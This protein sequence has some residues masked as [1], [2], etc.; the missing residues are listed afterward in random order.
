MSIHES[1]GYSSATRVI[2]VSP[3]G[4]PEPRAAPSPPPAATNTA[5]LAV[6]TQQRLA[7]RVVRLGAPIAPW[8]LGAGGRDDP[9][10]IGAYAWPDRKLPCPPG[11][12][13]KE[14]ECHD[15]FASNPHLRVSVVLGDRLYAFVSTQHVLFPDGRAI[16]QKFVGGA[17]LLDD[18]DRTVA[19]FTLR[20]QPPEK[21]RNVDGLGGLVD[22]RSSGVI[23]LEPCP[24][25]LTHHYEIAPVYDTIQDAAAAFEATWL[26]NALAEYVPPSKAEPA[27]RSRRAPRGTPETPTPA[28]AKPAAPP[29][30]SATYPSEI[31][32]KTIIELAREEFVP[33]KG[34]YA[35]AVFDRVTKIAIAGILAGTAT[36]INN[37]DPDE[38]ERR[39]FLLDERNGV[40]FD[41]TMHMLGVGDPGAGKGR[42]QTQ[43]ERFLRDSGTESQRVSSGSVQGLLGSV[44]EKGEVVEGVIPRLRKA[45]VVFFPEF[46]TALEL[47]NSDPKNGQNRGAL[48]EW[49]S[50]H[51]YNHWVSKAR[52]AGVRR[53]SYAILMGFLQPAFLKEFED[54]GAGSIRRLVILRF[55]PVTRDATK[56]F[57]TNVGSAFLNVNS[58]NL[59]AIRAKLRLIRE[60][61]RPKPGGV[62]TGR[63]DAWFLDQF[64]RGRFDH[65]DDY[66]LVVSITMG[67]YLATLWFGADGGIELPSPSERPELLEIIDEV[68]RQRD[69]FFQDP[70]DLRVRE[71]T[72][73]LERFGLRTKHHGF[74]TVDLILNALA[75][76]SRAS[77]GSA[78]KQ[79]FG[80]TD[81][82]KIYHRGLLANPAAAG[83]DDP[84]IVEWVPDPAEYAGDERFYWTEAETSARN[85]EQYDRALKWIGWTMPKTGG[86]RPTLYRFRGDTLADRNRKTTE[87]GG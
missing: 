74:L 65:T 24:V 47:L 54:T 9:Q 21:L 28:E 60:R 32:T 83:M 76:T 87:N 63:V 45:G 62:N 86:R 53:T 81:R 84:P 82:D 66:R 51:S 31:S 11:R 48:L 35:K 71:D 75:R 34:A 85:D 7:V 26:P 12:L 8:E 42:V 1:D 78:R 59:Q 73:A 57:V 19:L 43:L 68:F 18:R 41:F 16:P 44:L 64:D 40:P 33:G 13:T 27:R 52:D 79:I 25:D 3:V 56:D 80:W 38:P 30:V 50:S 29:P 10:F 37:E 15:L 36:W 70:D 4:D 2:T 67:Y 58:E 61:F 69:Q 14:Q 23:F 49:M 5:V 6:E 72:E 17:Y 55:P 46:S 39:P 22:I 20:K 77:G